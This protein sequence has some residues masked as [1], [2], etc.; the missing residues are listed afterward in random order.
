M[1]A[2]KKLTRRK[3]FTP[4]AGATSGVLSARS[5]ASSDQNAEMSAA[6]KHQHLQ[7]DHKD[8]MSVN[9]LVDRFPR[10]HPDIVL[11]SP[12]QTM[13]RQMG[14]VVTP[15]IPSL[16]YRVE[17]NVKVFEVIAQPVEVFL[18]EQHSGGRRHAPT[19][20]EGHQRFQPRP[21]QRKTMPA[22][23]ITG[24]VLARRLK[25]PRAIACGSSYAT[26]CP[27]RLLFISLARR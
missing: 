22:W 2:S 9:P 27:S 17:G 12:P 15:G 20:P 13:G 5:A 14:R 25:Q 19:I 6:D 18:T 4:F 24:T 7:T 11:S 21:S 10:R 3:L 23:A 26:N 16:G 1:K 8:G